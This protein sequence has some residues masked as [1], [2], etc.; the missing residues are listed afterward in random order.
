M[1]SA[2]TLTATGATNASGTESSNRLSDNGIRSDPSALTESRR[3]AATSCKG[4]AT[5]VVA[6]TNFHPNMVYGQTIDGRPP[7]SDDR[8]VAESPPE[9]TERVPMGDTDLSARFEKVSD[10]AKKA[11]EEL[12]AAGEMTKDQLQADV[13]IARD[14]AAASA[15]K[16]KEKAHASGDKVSSQWDEIRGKWQ[17]HVAKV[18]ADVKAKKAELDAKEADTDANIAL[19]YAL[20][21]IDFATA[22]IEEA[23]YAALDAVYARA[24]AIALA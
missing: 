14:K 22:A 21:A 16:F 19:S 15:D 9:L 18:R 2:T 8:P 11:A 20:D 4:L 13:T 6:P 17:A 10:K 1:V 5:Q 3:S 24:R 12:H 7:G 23:E